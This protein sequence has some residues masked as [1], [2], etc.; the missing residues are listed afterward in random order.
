MMTTE[1]K[2]SRSRRRR[3]TRRSVRVVERLARFLITIGGIGTI[4]AVTLIC[5][6][7]VAVIVPLFA[8]AEVSEPQVVPGERSTPSAPIH[9]AVDEY[10]VIAAML[11]ED[12]VIHVTALETGEFVEE[13]APFTAMGIPSAWSISATGD[14][15][16][17]S[18]SDG[19]IRLAR[20]AFA[21]DF[22]DTENV[23]AELASLAPGERRVHEQSM[24]ERTPDGRFRRQRFVFTMAEPMEPAGMGRIERLAHIDEGERA[25]FVAWTADSKLVYMSAERRT[26]FLTGELGFAL[27]ESL[28]PYEADA[29]RGIPA[30]VRLT[31]IGDNVLLIWEDGHCERLDARIPE[32]T[33]LAEVFDLVEGDARLTALSFLIGN[34]TLLV[35]S[36]DGRLSAWF[37]T[38]PDGAGTLDGTVFV[39]AHELSTPGQAVTSLAPSPRSRLVLA[40]YA[41]GQVRLFHVTSERSLASV[42]SAELGEL[43][44]LC[45]MPKED[46]LVALGTRGLG[47]W[48]LDPRYPEAGARAFFAPVWYEGYPK[49]E[50]VWQAVGG[51]DDF[52][53]KLGFVPLVFG[54]LKATFYSMLFGAPLAL[55]AALF[56]SEFLDRRLRVPFKSTIEIMA[57]LPSVVLGFLAGIIVAP[58][59]QTVIPATLALFAALPLTLL[60]GAHVWQLLPQKLAVRWWGWP[61]LV[62]IAGALPVGIACALLLG[63]WIERLFFAGDLEL[64]LDGQSGR[65]LG[66]WMLLLLPLSALVV[67]LTGGRPL[68]GWL[69]ARSADWSRSKCATVDLVKFSSWILAA[70]VLALGVSWALDGLGFDPR[71]TFVDTYVQRNALVVGF[72]MGFAVIPIIYTLAEDA[73]SSV[74][75]H[76]RL[77]SLSAGATTWQ[78]SL[79]VVVPTA[80]SGLFSAVMIG[81]G[82]AVGETMIVLMA[83]GNTPVMELNIF[84]GFR[85][86]SANIAVE[87]PEAVQ[88]STHYRA[89]FLAALVLF[90]MT[91]VLNTA[92]ESMRIRFRRRAVQL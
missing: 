83:T 34:G 33:A 76:L 31:G 36:S 67:T 5:V 73:L 16:A 17:F 7:L 30:H 12:G 62:C 89:L 38:K 79:R 25:V 71:G 55:L 28:L 84:N 81:L 72:V 82:R 65:A 48:S 40:G 60:L 49:P 47:R 88:G 46:G 80:M 68:A 4:A 14:S 92:A 24:L 9:F 66:G 41:G 70:V 44:A 56:T 45:L 77:A 8:G 64:W 35:G 86:L 27:E 54:T 15:L 20:F 75:Q 58:F 10:G 87:L 52:E 69:R 91:F 42:Q 74:P 2:P 53:S 50:H 37:G 78:T 29:A 23:P 22:P 85:T 6:F 3:E 32:R 51:T 63:P 39:R 11:G 18:F 13:L 57:S 21:T 26:N 1:G 90:A 43:R 19:S 59:V 61:K